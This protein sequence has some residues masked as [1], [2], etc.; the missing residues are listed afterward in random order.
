MKTIVV[1]FAG[2]IGSGKTT[3]SR[4]VSQSLGW[5]FVSF[6]DYV[7][8]IARV[9][10][11]KESREVLQQMG[12]S[13]V[14]EGW[15][16]FCRAVLAEVHWSPGE[17]LVIDGVRHAE[18]M[19]SLRTLVAPSELRLVFIAIDQ[20]TRE[21]RLRAEGIVDPQELPRID[22]H[23]T[24]VQVSTELRHIADLTVLGS[25]PE[26]ELLHEVLDL[27]RTWQQDD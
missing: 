20:Q 12:A 5:Q 11:L 21:A 10:G 25:L 15:D 3:L 7:R 23:S 18:I 4:A 14:D 17:S 19:N 27:I 26:Q 1:A 2:S 6:G 13:L 8:R 9:R 24:E 22:S 16:R